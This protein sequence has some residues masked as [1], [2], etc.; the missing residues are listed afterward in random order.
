MDPAYC[1]P[2]V[3]VAAV[4]AA[5]MMLWS[6]R[7]E[8]VA[9]IRSIRWSHVQGRILSVHYDSQPISV[10]RLHYQYFVDLQYEYEVDGRM[11]L[12]TRISFDESLLSVRYGWAAGTRRP[13]L[14][15]RGQSGGMR[16]PPHDATGCLPCAV[17]AGD[18]SAD[19]LT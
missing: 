5:V 10:R 13:R 7:R 16:D 9:R 8:V 14:L 18:G 17:A 12:G 3:R 6:V 11:Y 4:V 19:A 2:L 15:L 1:L